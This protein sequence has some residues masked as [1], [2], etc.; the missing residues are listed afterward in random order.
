VLIYT[1]LLTAKLTWVGAVDAPVSSVEPITTIRPRA[2]VIYAIISV[3]LDERYQNT[4]GIQAQW[5]K[6]PTPMA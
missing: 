3:K 1:T 5:K 2:G 6:H 4:G